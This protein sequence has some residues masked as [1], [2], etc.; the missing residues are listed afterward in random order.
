MLRNKKVHAVAYR[1]F[2]VFFV[3]DFFAMIFDINCL[4][5]SLLNK[6]SCN[7]ELV[8]GSLI[9]FVTTRCTLPICCI[10]LGS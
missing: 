10:I 7:F 8:G 1:L 9:L 6:I 5:C 4:L 3:V 2:A